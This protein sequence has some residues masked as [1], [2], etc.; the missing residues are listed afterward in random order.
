MMHFAR[1]QLCQTTRD[2]VCSVADD[3]RD[4][5][6]EPLTGRPRLTL[7]VRSLPRYMTADR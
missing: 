5:T 2:L 7:A 3:Q 6:S 4:R 1:C